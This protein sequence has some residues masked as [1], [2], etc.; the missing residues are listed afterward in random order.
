MNSKERYPPAVG[1]VVAIYDYT[2]EEGKVLFQVLRYNPK[3]FRNRR[4]D[5]HGG[6]IWNLDG[7]RP[8]VYRLRD[9]IKANT[10]LI[11]EGEKDVETTYRLGLPDGWAATCNP[12]GAA[13]WHS[14]YSEVLRG[15][16]VVICPDTDVAGQLHLKQ[17]VRNLVGKVSEIW[18]V[19]LPG[20]VKDLTEWAEAGGTPEQ[21]A[22]LL[23]GAK[24]F[25]Y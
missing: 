2:D 3:A 21:F 7:V 24:R 19:I 20:S 17:V 14:E 5:G 15:K 23:Q 11:L 1:K 6:W 9:V 16:R 13:Q 10:V 12:F 18:M 8:V 25:N 22:A 4:Q